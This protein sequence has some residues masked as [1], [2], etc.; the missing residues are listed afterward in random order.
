M[1]RTPA[2]AFKKRGVKLKK[3]KKNPKILK[4]NMCFLHRKSAFCVSSFH[5]KTHLDCI[6]DFPAMSQILLGFPARVFLSMMTFFIVPSKKK[7]GHFSSENAICRSLICSSSTVKIWSAEAFVCDAYL[8]RLRES[9]EQY[10]GG[11]INKLTR[12]ALILSGVPT[13]YILNKKIKTTTSVKHLC[14][15]VWSHLC[16]SAILRLLKG[17]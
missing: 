9:S 17:V 11:N 4:W 12:M 15:L 14:L 8:V 3:F 7:K 10:C 13:I 16:I 2:N 5:I 1:W 6:R